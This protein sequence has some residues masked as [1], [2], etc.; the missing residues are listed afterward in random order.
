MA[1]L[2]KWLSVRLQTK[3]L[4]VRI[5]LQSLKAMLSQETDKTKT[6]NEIDI[7]I[8]SLPKKHDNTKKPSKGVERPLQVKREEEN[9]TETQE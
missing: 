5:P 4:W 3:W 7:S 6:S 1:S 8:E 9:V 2:A